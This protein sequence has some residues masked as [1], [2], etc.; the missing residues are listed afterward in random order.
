MIHREV[1]LNDLMKFKDNNKIKLISGMRQ[2]GK[3][4]IVK[5]FVKELETD[6][7]NNIIY[8]ECNT[9]CDLLK[10]K[11]NLEDSELPNL[12]NKKIKIDKNNYIFFDEIQDLFNWKYILPE[13]LSKIN[14][15]KNITIDLYFIGINFKRL[16]K[17]FKLEYNHFEY[18]EINVLPL[19]FREFLELRREYNKV[20]LDNASK[21]EREEILIQVLNKKTEFEIDKN[22]DYSKEFKEYVKYGSLPLLFE[23]NNKENILKNLVF[24]VYNTIFLQDIIKRNSIK[25]VLLLER[26]IKYT[27]LNLGN[28]TSSKNLCKYLK[29]DC[30]KTTPTTVLD[31]LKILE[32]SYLFYSVP[33]YDIAKDKEL[34]TLPKYYIGDIGINNAIMGFNEDIANNVLENIVFLELLHRD[35]KIRIGKYHNNEISFVVKT[36]ETR[37]YYQICKTINDQKEL[38][39]KCEPLELIKDNY[40]KIVLTLDKN[41]KMEWKGIKFVNIIDFLLESY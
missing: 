19:S 1:Y 33:R 17:F 6:K 41:V 31:Y 23:Y 16:K 37:K 4:V 5:E 8:I 21:E 36:P 9:D 38:R 11:N 30:K 22:K 10:L 7:N 13:L 28:V 20:H 32:N 12:I 18:N 15:N 34:K 39:E 40:E 27:L 24:G 14:E 29:K 2:S 26:I 25:N 35:C 3:T